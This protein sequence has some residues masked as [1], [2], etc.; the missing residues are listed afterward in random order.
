MLARLEKALSNINKNGVERRNIIGCLDQCTCKMLRLWNSQDRETVYVYKY[1]Q[2]M[3]TMKQSGLWS[4]LGTH[5]SLVVIRWLCIS[6]SSEARKFDF[7]SQIWPW[8]S[9]S[10]ATQNNR[11]LNLCILHL[12]SKFGFP[13]LNGWWVMV[14][15]SSKWGKFWLWP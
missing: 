4:S 10:I 6:S 3:E 13:S 7:L 9:R 14:R 2:R 5:G 15:T 11:D 12:W 1:M 8:G